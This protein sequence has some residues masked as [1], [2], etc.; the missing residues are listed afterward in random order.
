MNPAKNTCR[1]PRKNPTAI[2]CRNGH[3]RR[4]Y[5]AAPTGAKA[6]YE[7]LFADSLCSD[8]EKNNETIKRLEEAMTADDWLYMAETC[9]NRTAKSHYLKMAK[10]KSE[11]AKEA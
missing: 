1:A 5:E 3:W 10:V 8:D 9:D 11:N 2:F 4:I 6:Y 7:A